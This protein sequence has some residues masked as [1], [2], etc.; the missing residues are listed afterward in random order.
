MIDDSDKTFFGGSSRGPNE[1]TVVVPTP[2]RRPPATQVPPTPATA[3]KPG[4][5]LPGFQ[6]TAVELQYGLNPLVASASELI[7]LLGELRH[8]VRVQNPNQLR[9]QVVSAIKQF[10]NT[11]N[12]KGVP[13]DVILSARYV[14]CSAIDEAVLNTPWGAEVGWSRASLLSTFH[15]ETFGGEKVFMILERLQA[16]PAKYIDLIELVYVCLSLGFEGKYKLDARGRDQ[17]EIIRDNLSRIIGTHRGDFDRD[18]SP[19]WRGASQ[20]VKRIMEYVPMWVIV[21]VVVALLLVSY[22]G[23]RFWLESVTDPQEETLLELV[24]RYQL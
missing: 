23:Y 11:A 20:S 3:A 19:R 22:S 9:T 5:Q 7:A 2:G 15:N 4:V 6:S 16:A 17:L 10:E 1:R 21:A 18:L 8:T 12:V 13:A 14:L 24:E